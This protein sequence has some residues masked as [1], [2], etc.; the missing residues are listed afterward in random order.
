MEPHLL[1][2]IYGTTFISTQPT[3]LSGT[4]NHLQ[5]V[6]TKV[7]SSLHHSE[8][9]FN[10]DLD[11]NSFECNVEEVL[12]TEPGILREGIDFDD[13]GP[14]TGAAN[15]QQNQNGQFKTFLE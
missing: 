10:L 13:F 4:N 8:L 12:E 2:G 1:N 7:M 11:P 5:H 6:D 14:S 3:F 15:L 9:D